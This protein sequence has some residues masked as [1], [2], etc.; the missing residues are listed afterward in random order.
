MCWTHILDIEIPWVSESVDV[1]MFGA[2]A[3]SACMDLMITRSSLT[4]SLQNHS[5]EKQLYN[6]LLPSG[7]SFSAEILKNQR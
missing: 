7:F 1:A 6:E 5:E 4:F 3:I 2:M